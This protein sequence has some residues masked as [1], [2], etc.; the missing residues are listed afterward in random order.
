MA[1]YY[2]LLNEEESRTHQSEFEEPEPVKLTKKQIKQQRVK[3][4]KLQ[5][6]K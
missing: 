2:E 3:E 4:A 6:A 5:A 1:A